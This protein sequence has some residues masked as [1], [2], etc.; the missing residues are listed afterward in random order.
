MSSDGAFHQP[1]PQVWL[2]APFFASDTGQSRYDRRV[3][4]EPFGTG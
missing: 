1:A 3:E 4:D 2:G